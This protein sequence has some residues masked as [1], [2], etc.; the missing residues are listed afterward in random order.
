M[1]AKALAVLLPAIALL[2]GCYSSSSYP[3]RSTVVEVPPSKTVVVAPPALPGALGASA[4]TATS[5]PLSGSSVPVSSPPVRL[6]ASEVSATLAGNTAQGVSA[7]GLPYAT[8]F[9]PGGRER[10]REGEFT[11]YGTWYVLT[12]GR[13]CSTL[14]RLSGGTQE[15]YVM[16]R[17]GNMLTFDQPDGVPVG[18]VT[19]TAGNTLSL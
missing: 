7:N 17:S 14:T 15:C 8:Y 16:Y 18:S 11:D 5:P 6:S 19:V 9:A 13:L 1:P 10:F 4:T 3:P 2:T 12:D